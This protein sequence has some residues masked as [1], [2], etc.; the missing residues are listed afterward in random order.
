[1]WSKLGVI[2]S[3]TTTWV[4]VSLVYAAFHGNE[5]ELGSPTFNILEAFSFFGKMFTAGVPDVPPEFSIIWW[6]MAFALGTSVVLLV[7]G[8]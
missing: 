3:V 7:R 6:L 1:M 2:I 4:I 5:A 8:D